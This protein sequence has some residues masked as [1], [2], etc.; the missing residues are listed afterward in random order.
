MKDNSNSSG[1]RRDGDI[2]A[3][4]VRTFNAQVL[5]DDVDEALGERIATIERGLAHRAYSPGHLESAIIGLRGY[6]GTHPQ[7][8]ATLEHLVTEA[9]RLGISRNAAQRWFRS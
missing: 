9:V 7:A 4:A 6:Q 1:S 8:D 3:L 2:V 5:P